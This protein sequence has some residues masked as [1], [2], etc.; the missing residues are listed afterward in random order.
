LKKFAWR[1]KS[2]KGN[3]FR[4]YFVEL[5]KFIEYYKNHI[6]EMIINKAIEGKAVYIMLVNKGRSV[7]KPGET[8]K[9]MRKR[10]QAYATGRDKHPDIKFIML[11]D[12]PKKVEKCTKMMIDKTKIRGNQ[13]L[14]KID[15][16]ILKKVM[17]GCAELSQVIEKY[18]D[19]KKLNVHIVFD[20]T[21]TI[22]YLDLDN[23]VIGMEKPHKYVKNKLK[24]STKKK[25]KTK[26]NSDS[27][28]KKV[29][30]KKVTK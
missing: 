17:M 4:D 13:E 15:F 18:E 9:G 5:R 16:D 21:K 10:L 1:Q 23:N 25:S 12:D 22:E 3:N 29:S 30:K 26:S 24:S 20:D 11:V 2:E 7:F 14:Y 19:R 27:K 28:P 8:I 6:S